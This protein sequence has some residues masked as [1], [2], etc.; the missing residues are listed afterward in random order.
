MARLHHRQPPFHPALEAI[1]SSL[2]ESESTTIVI[3]NAHN[4]SREAPSE[5]VVALAEY[6]GGKL[7]FVMSGK[8]HV[9]RWLMKE[10]GSGIAGSLPS[11]AFAFTPDEITKLLEA[12]DLHEGN[13]DEVAQ[14]L[15]NATQGWPIAVQLL[16]RSD[17]GT[18]FSLKNS[19][20]PVI[21]TDYI[22]NEVLSSLSPELKDF[23]LTVTVTDEI[24]PALANHL[25]G[26]SQSSS[27]LDECRE[28]GLFL[29]LLESGSGETRLRWHSVFSQSCR[30]IAKHRD[31]DR[32]NQ[33]QR[34]TA[35]WLAPSDPTEA[36]NHANGVD[37]PSF[38][39][40]MIEDIW[41]Q[42]ITSS[43]ASPLESA[44]LKASA[45]DNDVPTL[46]YIRAAC[47]A[48]EGDPNGTQILK[49]RAD[50]A[51]GAMS[52][53]PAER[54]A[55]TRAFVDVILLDRPD[56]LAAALETV[57]QI[58]KTSVLG[59]SLEIHG[60]FL[61]AW[62]HLKL[63]ESSPRAVDLFRSVAETAQATGYD[64]IAKRATTTIT[65]A[66]A[67]AAH[68]SKAR[69]HLATVS[70]DASDPSS[71]RDPFG[72]YLDLWPDAFLSFW[73]GDTTRAIRLY[74]DMDAVGA[75]H[76][77]A[78]NLARIYFGHSAAL[79]EDPDLLNEA[80]TIL[81]SIGG[82]MEG[83]IPWPAYKQITL[84]EIAWARDD[85]AGA[86]KRLDS[87]DDR[88]W[89]PSTQAIAAS[90][91]QRIG[92]PDRALSTIKQIKS[93]TLISYSYVCVQVT[94]A[95]IHW[96]RCDLERAHELLEAGLETAVTEEV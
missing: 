29:D 68:M 36:L 63:N 45:S 56:E 46:L 84:A 60:M 70:M 28:R 44:C 96:E 24:S 91:W 53:E 92:Y 69:K 55:I 67:V 58:L 16:L 12:A 48:V 54:S 41:L 72:N 7:R 13:R 77:T 18:L 85:H 6:S 31:P 95:A 52:G 38:V 78:S 51:A 21:L 94:L 39:V 65:S 42:M 66:L 15:H 1:I 23:L 93:D 61:A 64:T 32:F 71:P 59:R 9:S 17:N 73:R 89:A 11:S 40:H 83:G 19:T 82:E 4:G 10:L 75:P 3:D 26:N 5:I 20:A 87:T 34:A 14:A 57:E 35:T 2:P 49:A 88:F 50:H 22:E 25:T 43:H 86:A 33:I 74:R 47:R 76:T 79:S 27:L 81:D 62:S 8:R 30:A 80:E 90:L 37:D